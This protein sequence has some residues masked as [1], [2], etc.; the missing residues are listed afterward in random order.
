MVKCPECGK[1]NLSKDD[2]CEKCGKRLKEN[3]FLTIYKEFNIWQKVKSNRLEKRSTLLLIIS[4]ILAFSFIFFLYKAIDLRTQVTGLNNENTNLNSQIISLES[5]IE[6]KQGIIEEK[7][8]EVSELNDNI[9]ALK[10][11]INELSQQK[12]KIKY[13]CSDGRIQEKLEDCSKKSESSSD[14]VPLSPSETVE[15]YF[16]KYTAWFFTDYDL[17]Y[18]LL[19]SSIKPESAEHLEVDIHNYKYALALGMVSCSYVGVKNEQISGNTAT[20]DL[21]SK[22]GSIEYQELNTNTVNLIKE[23]GEWKLKTKYLC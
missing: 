13:Q 20:V 11:T 2:F 5:K 14:T 17:M 8:K 19:A 1:K 7:N 22:T 23:G 12:T 21:I 18:D 10:E 15:T 9:K 3:K 6:K 16:K 4:V